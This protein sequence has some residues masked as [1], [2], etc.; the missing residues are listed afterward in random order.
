MLKLIQQEVYKLVQKRSTTIGL[1]L[2]A[3]VM[4]FLQQSQKSIPTCLMPRVSLKDSI[5]PGFFS[6]SC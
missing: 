6:C 4:A 1:G 2:L 5:R 3:A